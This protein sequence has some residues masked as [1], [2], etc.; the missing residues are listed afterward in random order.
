MNGHRAA[1]S[2]LRQGSDEKM[3]KVATHARMR[4]KR[5]SLDRALAQDLLQ[6][7]NVMSV[8]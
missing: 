5:R 1:R 6:H 3:F 8:D 7:S 2:A 4:R